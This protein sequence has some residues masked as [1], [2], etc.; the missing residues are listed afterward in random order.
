M[1]KMKTIIS[2]SRV[3]SDPVVSV[4]TD[5]EAHPVRWI[6]AL[7]QMCT[8]KKV[9][10]RLT[11]LGIENYVPTQTEIHQWSDRKKKVE[12]VVIPMVVF[13]RADEAT[14]RIL[15]MQSFI[16]KILTYP[17]QTAAAVIP[18]E[19]IERL[20]FMLQEADSPVELMPENL[21]VGDRVRIVRGALQ[22]L[23]GELCKSVPEKSMVAIRIDGLGYACVSVSV[24]DLEQK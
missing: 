20:K 1:R 2:P 18:D 6:A 13:L 9:G 7:V 12:R 17:G 11:K 14:E 10:D 19:Q 24:G 16:R 3:D 4:T 5:R 8:E 21:R 22:G 15:R 23:E